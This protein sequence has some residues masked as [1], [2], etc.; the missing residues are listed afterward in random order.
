M[1]AI[2]VECSSKEMQGVHEV[3][4]LAI[5]TTVEREIKIKEEKERWAANGGSGGGGQ[6]GGGSERHHKKRKGC[7]IL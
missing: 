2:Y 6:L 7:R 3:F 1:G 4:D 5:D